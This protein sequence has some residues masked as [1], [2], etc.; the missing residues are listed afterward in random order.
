MY[1]DAEGSGS[2]TAITTPPVGRDGLAIAMTEAAAHGYRLVV[3]EMGCYA[4]NPLAP[5]AW[6]HSVAYTA[7][8]A[9]ICAG[10]PGGRP[11][12]PVGGRRRR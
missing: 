8:S 2:T 6:A 5:A 9:A 11:A 10:T 3:G 7:A 4:A 1:L 12:T